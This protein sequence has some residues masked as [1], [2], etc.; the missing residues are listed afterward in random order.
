M[1]LFITLEYVKHGTSTFNSTYRNIGSTFVFFQGL[2]LVEIIHSLTGLTKGNPIMPLLQIGARNMLLHYMIDK[3]EPIQ[4]S[5]LITYLFLVWSMIEVIRYP[6]YLA[7]LYHYDIKWLTILRYTI[8]IPLYPSGFFLESAIIY[9]NLPYLESTQK[10]SI[11]L[12]NAFNISFPLPLILKI[13]LCSTVW[14]ASFYLFTHMY[15][16]MK[17]ALNA[18]KTC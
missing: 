6:F 4:T 3:I 2:Q 16:Q 7:H 11:Q 1:F 10:Y 18:Y 12:P 14:F 9:L 17:K 5:H 8:W 13:H 15:K